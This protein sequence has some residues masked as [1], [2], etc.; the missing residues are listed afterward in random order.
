MAV[1]ITGLFGSAG[2]VD[3]LAN[4]RVK[5]FIETSVGRDGNLKARERSAQNA[6]KPIYVSRFH[7][8]MD[9]NQAG[10]RSI[11]RSTINFSNAAR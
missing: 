4:R 9:E 6:G 1:R 8:A 5:K 11:L 3:L 10:V 7:S 2:G